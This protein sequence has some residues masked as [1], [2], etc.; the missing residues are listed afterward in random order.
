MLFPLIIF[1]LIA[2][3]VTGTRIK[4]SKCI[5]NTLYFKADSCESFIHGVYGKTGRCIQESNCP[6]S[7]YLP[8]LCESKPIDVKC[9][10]N[11]TKDNKGQII[12][13]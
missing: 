13:H 10:F 5:L 11:T 3:S 7:N 6:N 12:Y 2:E 9:C 8:K 1:A 4:V